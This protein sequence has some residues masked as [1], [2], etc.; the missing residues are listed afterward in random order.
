MTLKNFLEVYT[1]ASETKYKSIVV[2]YSKVHEMSVKSA[3][4]AYFRIK[5]LIAAMDY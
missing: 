4:H 1:I 2:E 3:S 5:Y